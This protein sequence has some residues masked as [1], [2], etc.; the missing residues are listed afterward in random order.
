MNFYFRALVSALSVGAIYFADAF[1]TMISE[2]KSPDK[3]RLISAGIV[4]I[5][6]MLKDISSRVTPT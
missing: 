4:G 1:S 5:S 3:W 2:G 6:L